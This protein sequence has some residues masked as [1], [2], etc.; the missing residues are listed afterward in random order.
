MRRL[1][2]LLP[3]LATACAYDSG[4]AYRGNEYYASPYVPPVYNQG[5]AY[6]GEYDG[7]RYA[8][9]NYTSTYDGGYYG[10]SN[11]GF[12]GGENCGTPDEPKSCPPLP[13]R[14]LAYY[15]GDGW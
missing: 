13:R 6:E 11:S 15:P 7:S 1:I 10:R 3:L 8:A 9:R 2:I 12:Y 5:Y 14:P 4:Y